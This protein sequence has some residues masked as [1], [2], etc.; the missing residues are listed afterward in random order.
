MY[1]TKSDYVL[2]RECPHNVWIKKWKPE[3]YKQSPLSEFELHLIESGNMVEETARK[4][5]PEGVLVEGR[6]EAA[7][8][9]TQ[10]LLKQSQYTIFQA[11][12]SDGVLFAAIDILKQNEGGKLSIYE[13]K[14]SNTSKLENL[15]QEEDQDNEGGGIVDITDLKAMEKY[16]KKLFKDHHFFD[17]AFQVYLVRK[18][19]YDVSGAYLVRLNRQYV[20][21]AD[22]D[23][24]KLFVVEDVSTYIDEA[25]VAVEEEIKELM[26]LLNSS[27]EPSGPCCCIYKGR[28]KHCTTFDLHNKEVPAYSVHDLTRVG[29]SKK[30]L[31]ELIDSKVYDILDIPADFELSKKMKKQAEVHKLGRASID[32]D[33]IRVELASLQF[34]LYFLDYE[35]F[36]P[37]IPRFRGYKPYQQIPFQFSMHR[38]DSMDAALVHEEFLYIGD[39]DPSLAFIQA[40]ENVI[41]DRGNILVWYKPF[42][43]SHINK[44]LAIRLPEH[45]DFIEK[46]NSRMFDL[47]TIFSNQL[48][49]HPDFHGSASIKKVLP[50]LCPDLSYKELEI[51]N[52]SEAM[53]TWNKLV[54]EG[55]REEDRIRIEA[56]MR[57]YCGLD[58]YAMYAI[59]KKLVELA[60]QREIA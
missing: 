47:M 56:A 4:R 32:Y 24:N 45:S 30:K 58:T 16:K 17:L 54:T 41:G 6:G 13:V 36:N 15:D 12:F 39:Q 52:G 25:I 7:L 3:L 57:E 59:W 8:D 44:R 43:E 29:N 23:L 46:V 5:F 60:P 9:K 18:V 33:Q 11:A 53:N 37:A 48:H 10:E 1:I 27:K 51:G 40:L 31:Q 50:V 2:W 34:P 26:S 21:G 55:A 49:V 35:S 22:L 42:E 38:L 14:A 20:R 19:G 28:S